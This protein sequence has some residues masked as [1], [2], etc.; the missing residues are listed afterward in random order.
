MEIKLNVDVTLDELEKMWQFPSRGETDEEQKIRMKRNELLLQIGQEI[1]DN[2]EK[3][4]N[5]ENG[6]I[7]KTLNLDLG[8][9]SPVN[10]TIKEITDTNVIVGYNNST[11][12]RT[13]E[14]SVDS[15]EYL[16]GLKIK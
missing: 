15:F 12:G 6:L 4:L 10:V 16:S 13:E 9:S 11:P 8:S 2:N 14:F 5:M 3:L 1:S 7:G